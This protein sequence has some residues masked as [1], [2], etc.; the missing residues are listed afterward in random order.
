[1]NPDLTV[2][3]RWELFLRSRYLSPSWT[4]AFSRPMRE[5]HRP[6]HRFEAVFPLI[7]LAAFGVA[8]WFSL[9]QI[10]RSMLPI[11]ALADAARRISH[12]ELDARVTIE[13]R[14][15]FGELGRTFNEMA[16]EIG[17]QIQVLNTVNEIGTGLSAE[18]DT[19][20]LLD[21]ILC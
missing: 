18:Q 1:M 4:I 7:A 2:S 3:A 9:V 8:V 14:D 5:I 10:R 15:E 16:S 17:R 21:Q 20:A 13:T 6:L 11:E 19:D 12:G